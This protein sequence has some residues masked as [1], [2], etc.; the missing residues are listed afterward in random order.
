MSCTQFA[1]IAVFLYLSFA[2]FGSIGV[3]ELL[4]Q[5]RCVY[6]E[7][8]EDAWIEAVFVASGASWQVQNLYLLKHRLYSRL[9]PD[10]TT[11]GAANTAQP[12]VLGLTEVCFTIWRLAKAVKK[13]NRLKL[14]RWVA[15]EVD[16]SS[17]KEP[18]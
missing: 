11:N 8:L 17:L 13:K 18:K 14:C 7:D 6:I 2:F 16:N 4:N 1:V 9:R 3:K 15:T 12:V 10:I 5:D